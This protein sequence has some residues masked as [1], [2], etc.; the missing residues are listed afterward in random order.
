M[1]DELTEDE[2]AKTQRVIDEYSAKLGKHDSEPLTAKKIFGKPKWNAVTDPHGFGIRLKAS[3]KAGKM[4]NISWHE[5][6]TPQHATQYII[7]G[8]GYE[9]RLSGPD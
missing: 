4:E 3:V 6:D 1:A 2:R 9:S 7:T 5:V 8:C